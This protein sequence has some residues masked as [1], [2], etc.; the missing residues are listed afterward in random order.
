MQ[1]A[2]IS[3]DMQ[4]QCM[5]G[6]E[7]SQHRSH[8]NICNQ[9][10]DNFL[11]VWIIIYN[12]FCSCTLY[13]VHNRKCCRKCMLSSSASTQLNF[14]SN[15]G[16]GGLNFSFSSQ[17]AMRNSCEYEVK[18]VEDF[19]KITSGLLQ[20]YSK[21]RSLIQRPASTSYLLLRACSLCSQ[22]Q[23]SKTSSQECMEVPRKSVAHEI[24]LEAKIPDTVVNIP[25]PWTLCSK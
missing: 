16:C 23:T 20:D 3:Y 15:Y 12:N 10:F 14:N 13:T 8:G 17:P 9:A 18:V 11:W 24:I 4:S 21:T 22:N 1:G 6:Q 19:F 2:A 5:S 7:E 25:P